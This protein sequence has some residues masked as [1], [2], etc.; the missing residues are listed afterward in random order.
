LSSL[1]DTLRNYCDRL[2]QALVA[3]LPEE[4][5]LPNQLH[6]AMRYSTLSGGKRIR[7]SLVYATGQSLGAPLSALD[8]PACAVEI[9]HSFSLVHDDMPC[10]DDDDL[11]RGKPTCHKAFDE[12]T[13]LLVG[14]A[15]QSLAFDMLAN[16]PA[17]TIDS[18]RRL[19]MVGVLAR[20]VGS[21]GM[22]GG[23]AIDIESVGQTLTPERLEDMHRRKTGELIHASVM[24]GALAAKSS[25]DTIMTALDQYGEAIGLAFQVVDDILDVTADT[26]TLGKPQGSDLAQN[27]PTYPS[28]LG[29]DAARSRAEELYQSALASLAPLGDNGQTLGE[30]ADFIVHR[31]Q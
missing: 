10:M 14:D 24:L 9:I 18:E 29:L 25:D 20:A 8:V 11:R 4:H 6:A 31:N 19:R 28:I 15:L 12:A 7:A 21:Y 22:A 1:T 3:R 16:D 2:E 26:A 17:L 13:A 27:K 23:Q 30:I 5:A